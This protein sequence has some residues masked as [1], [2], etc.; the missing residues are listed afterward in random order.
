M[1]PTR[2]F[3]LAAATIAA[4][5][6][7]A[8]LQAQDRLPPV[9]AHVDVSLLYARPLGEFA[10]NIDRGFGASAGAALLLRPGSPLSLRGDLGVINY[11]NE[12]KEV[13]LS[14]T[15]GCRIMVDLTTSNNIVFGA[16]GP[17][18]AV[19]AG[20]IRPYVHGGIG[21]AYFGTTSSVRGRGEQDNFAN[22]TNHQDLTFAANG[23]GGMRFDLPFGETP[24]LVD[25]GVRYHDNGRVEYLR[26]GDITDRPDGSIELHP[27]R[28]EANLLSFH[29]GVSIGLRP[30]RD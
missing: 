30:G 29:V 1:R 25:L 4:L 12:T 26:R 7:A 8:P 10:E 18:L 9:I 13:C 15:V 22:T 16:V 17:Q 23:G 14:S 5:S 27:R 21:F 11:G 24:V 2:T 28:S 20:P 6:A 3:V 19:P